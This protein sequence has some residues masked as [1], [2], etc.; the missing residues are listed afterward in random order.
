MT[1]HVNCN[2][3]DGY[4][5]HCAAMLCSLLVNNPGMHFAVHIFIG[6]LTRE[7]RALLTALCDRYGSQCLFQEIDS[8]R[9]EGLTFRPDSP[10]TEAAYYRYLLP[11]LL[12][13][14]VHR[15]LYL[16]C[17]VVVM[18]SVAELFAM[19]IDGCGVAALADSSPY[20]DGHRVDMG[21]PLGGEAFCSGV[22]MVNLDYWRQNGSTQALFDYSRR[23]RPKVYLEDQD[24]LNFVFRGHWFKLPF[25]WGRTPWSV[26]VPGHGQHPFDYYEYLYDTRIL[27]YA[28]PLKP[29]CTT[30]SPDRKH[31]KKYLALSGFKDPKFKVLPRRAK[32][33]VWKNNARYAYSR[34]VRPAVPS[35][36][37]TLVADALAILAIAGTALLRPRRLGRQMLRRLGRKYRL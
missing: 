36:V 35:I 34:W 33:A 28:G 25:K 7:N 18:G 20:T 30:W 24:A 32:L 26:I 5:Q 13:P 19:N 16:D 11:E 21:L 23:P 10:V 22:M 4:V 27:H 2:T 29:W 8:S 14:D 15:V 12:G 6:T 37:E 1:Y 31:Y 9:F 3:D 17:D